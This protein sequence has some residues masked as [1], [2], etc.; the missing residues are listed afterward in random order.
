[1][2]SR[3]IRRKSVL[4]RRELDSRSRRHLALVK[5]L[6]QGVASYRPQRGLPRVGEEVY[7]LGHLLRDVPDPHHDVLVAA[8]DADP[9]GHVGEVLGQL[10]EVAEVDARGPARQAGHREEGAP[11][12]LTLTRGLTLVHLLAARL[13]EGGIGLIL[14][15]GRHL[16]LQRIVDVRGPRPHR[17]VSRRREN[18]P[19]ED[20]EVLEVDEDRR[21]LVDG[22]VDGVDLLPGRSPRG[23]P[24]QPPALLSPP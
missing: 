1:M 24:R 10:D 5:K 19:L 13:E 22:D 18:L 21:K 15:L 2:A 7:Q 23:V 11:L 14:K 20:G 9:G 17:V 4:S 12:V 6:D 3:W 16:E 8:G